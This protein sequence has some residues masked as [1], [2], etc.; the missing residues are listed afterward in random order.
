MRNK[1]KNKENPFKNEPTNSNQNFALFLRA[2]SP[3]SFARTSRYSKYTGECL[4]FL[5]MKEIKG[6]FPSPFNPPTCHTH[7]PHP[8]RAI[9]NSCEFKKADLLFRVEAKNF[10][11]QSLINWTDRQVDPIRSALAL[12]F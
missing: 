2:F 12:S 3:L 5:K 10:V 7:S 8:I 11:H 4:I 6:P 1:S 9:K